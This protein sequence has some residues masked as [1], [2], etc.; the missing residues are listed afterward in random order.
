MHSSERY[1][2]QLISLLP[3]G[4]LAITDESNLAKLLHAF[5][6]EIARIDARVDDLIDESL[7]SSVH[8]LLNE[9]ED[10]YGIYNRSLTDA[11]RVA[12]LK[13]KVL[14]VGQQNKEY[15][16]EIATSLGFDIE[17]EEFRPAWIELVAIG[18][19][20][21]SEINIFRWFV[22]VNIVADMQWNISELI[23]T[24]FQLKPGHTYV[25]FEFKGAEYSRAFYRND[26]NSIQHFDGKFLPGS[27]DFSF[28]DSFRNNYSYNG[29]NYTGGFGCG[30]GLSFN[31]AAGGAFEF[32][33]YNSEF[34]KP[35]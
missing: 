24:F 33:A 2:K 17:I 11:E 4:K 3:P 6:D 35:L 27:F 14:Q 13:S 1:K 7:V 32:N 34:D 15:F 16:E 23:E 5:S 22:W 29:V 9:W 10:D 31:F 28:D 19:Y 21:G 26:F 30:F 12:I 25:G 18:D 20:V 8:E